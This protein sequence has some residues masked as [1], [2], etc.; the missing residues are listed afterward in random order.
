MSVNHICVCGHSNLMHGREEPH[1]CTEC[2]TCAGFTRDSNTDAAPATPE[3]NVSSEGAMTTHTPAQRTPQRERM[4]VER[5]SYTKKFRLNYQHTD[6][7]R[8]VMKLYFT[9]GLYDD[10]RVGEVFVKADKA[11]TL[12]SGALDAAAIFMSMCLQAGAPL[13]EVVDKVKGTRFPP[14]GFTGDSDVPNC[15]SPLDLLA[16]WLE[17]RFIPKEN[18]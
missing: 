12:A 14:A 17:H 3:A 15:T 9:A 4:P 1:T 7:R 2:A 8:D 10:G 5:A 13:R 11:G 18:P 16:R 6:G